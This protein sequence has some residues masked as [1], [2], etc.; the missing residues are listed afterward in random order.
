MEG[1]ALA[2]VMNV[3]TAIRKLRQNRKYIL[4]TS[5]ILR[6]KAKKISLLT[7]RDFSQAFSMDRVS[8][9]LSVFYFLE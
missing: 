6:A 3:P 7:S 8:G 5:H 1:T 2:W 4:I 9:D